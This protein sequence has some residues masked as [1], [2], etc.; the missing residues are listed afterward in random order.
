MQP[1][2]N[3][4]L[5]GFMGTGKTSVGAP[6][7]RL[8]DFTFVDMDRLIET[9]EQRSVRRIF[10]EAGEPAFR[11]LERRLVVELSHNTRQVIATGGGVVLNPDNLQDF[12]RVAMVV[13]LWSRPE[14]IVQRLTTDS[15]RPRLDR[16]A[17]KLESI[18]S[19]L[20][21]RRACYESVPRRIDTSDLTT[22]HVVRQIESWY[23]TF[24]P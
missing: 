13:C 2:P 7:A 17:D 24:Q 4:V 12:M 22:N 8:L 14:V 1:P 6:L 9:R 3:I 18:R 21:A 16:P 23:R 19:L 11:M 10:D 20:E 5:T 15:T